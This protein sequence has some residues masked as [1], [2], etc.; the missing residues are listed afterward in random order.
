MR[1]KKGIT[2]IALVVTIIVLLILIGITISFVFSDNGVIAKARQAK[3]ETESAA[4]AEQKAM[5][6]TDPEEVKVCISMLEKY[7]S[8]FREEINKAESK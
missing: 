6:D 1:G 4:Q 2:L 8:S 7:I 5:E 3:Y